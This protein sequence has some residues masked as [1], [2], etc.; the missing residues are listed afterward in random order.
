MRFFIIIVL[1]RWFVEF[2]SWFLKACFQLGLL[3]GSG[4]VWLFKRK[5]PVPQV[6]PTQDANSVK[7]LRD[8]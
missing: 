8:E 5:K 3:L 2:M 6:D 1:I 7:S 4:V